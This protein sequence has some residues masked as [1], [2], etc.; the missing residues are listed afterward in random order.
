MLSQTCK[1]AIKAVIYLSGRCDCGGKAGAKEISDKIDA[2]EHTVGKALQ[3]LAKMDIIK[4]MK[5]PT[6]GFYLSEEQQEQPIY[7]IVEA[8][9]GKEI[10]KQCALGLTRC[11]ETRPCPLH[12]EYKPV[13][14]KIEKIFREN[15][16]KDLCDSIDDGTAFLI[17]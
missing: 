17:N 4:S 7:N 1:I 15:K 9:E 16:I 2:S 6:G 12:H 5:G 11:S 14:E 8:I 3:L 13:R 10:F